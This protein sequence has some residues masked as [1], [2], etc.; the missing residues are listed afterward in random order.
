MGLRGR[1]AE[2]RRASRCAPSSK[3]YMA[4]LESALHYSLRVEAGRPATL[5]GAQLA[6]FKCYVAT[7]AKVRSSLHSVRG[8]KQTWGWRRVGTPALCPH[9]DAALKLCPAVCASPRLVRAVLG[10]L[11]SCPHLCVW[12]LVWLVV[13]DGFGCERRGG[14]PRAEQ[15]GCLQKRRCHLQWVAVGLQLPFGSSAR[16]PA[17]C[18]LL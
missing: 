15:A 8:E 17:L 13:P 14:C 16:G 4:D 10:V 6:A 11:F 7:L 5:S 3:V 1:R 9:P 2:R 18:W 12:V